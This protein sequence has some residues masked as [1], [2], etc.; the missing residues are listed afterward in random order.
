MAVL[1][2]NT[3]QFLI[4]YNA[5]LLCGATVVAVNPLQSVEEIGRQIEATGSKFLIILDRLLNR[6]PEKHPELIVAEAAYYAPT[7]LRY[8]SH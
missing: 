1:L 4:S 7:R 8:L 6:L 3:P 5:I 2:P